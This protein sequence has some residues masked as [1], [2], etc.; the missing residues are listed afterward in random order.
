VLLD[1]LANQ[2]RADAGSGLL[3]AKGT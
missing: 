1:D 3:L 2:G